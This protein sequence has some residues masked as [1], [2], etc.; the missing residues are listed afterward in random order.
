MYQNSMFDVA[1]MMNKKNI[2]NGQRQRIVAY[3]QT[4]EVTT[5][6]KHNMMSQPSNRSD[7]ATAQT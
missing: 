6:T 7:P 2:T 5:T 4:D 1:L 3:A